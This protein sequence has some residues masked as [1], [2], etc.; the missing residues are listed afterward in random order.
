MLRNRV[1]DSVTGADPLRVEKTRLRGHET[2]PSTQHR[3]R[4][5]AALLVSSLHRSEIGSLTATLA[6][7]VIRQHSKRNFTGSNRWI[8]PVQP[9]LIA[10]MSN[11][12]LILSPMRTP[13]PSRAAL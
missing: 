10:E 3:S 13:P 9:V 2:T 11:V 7:T 1:T 12:S 8:Q 6:V 4:P 5:P